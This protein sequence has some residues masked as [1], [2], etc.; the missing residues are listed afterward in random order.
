MASAARSTTILRFGPYELDPTSGQL[1]KSGTLLKLH[2]QP[3][4]VLLLLVSEPGKVVTREEIQHCLWNGNTLVDCDG[5]INFCVKQIRAALCDDVEEPIYIETLPRR[6]Y[7]F[8]APINQAHGADAVIP[9]PAVAGNNGHEQ[10]VGPAADEVSP[11]D[12]PERL[13]ATATPTG[14]GKRAFVFVALAA[15]SLGV[16]L[17]AGLAHLY[18]RTAKLSEK[19]T[20]VLADLTNNTGDSVFDGALKQALTTELAQSPFLNLL[21]ES[22]INGTLRMMARPA[23]E[24]VTG[25]TGREICMRTGSKALLTS[26]ISKLGN[27][28]LFGLN[29]VECAN[30]AILASAN[31]EASSKENVLKAVSK[32]STSLRA[33]LGESLPSVQKY[34]VPIQATTSSL[35]ALQS[36]SIAVRLTPTEGDAVTIPF[37]ER[38]LQFDPNFASAY[39]SLARRYTNLNQ[40]SLALENATKA[41]ELRDHVTELEKLQ[42][43]AAYFRATGDLVSLNK[44]LE[45]WMGDYPR[46]SGPHARMCT[47]D[48]F[49]G[50]Y[51]KALE[52]CREA[53]RLDPDNLGSY[54]DLAQIYLDL[55][56]YDEAQQTCDQALA[57]NLPC[58]ALY[59]LDFLRG[60]TKGMANEVA[61]SV[62]KFGEEDAFLSR[63]SNTK[64]YYGQLRQAREL[65]QR[66]TEA[67]VRSGL[68]EAA[69]LWRV[70]AALREAEFGEIAEARRGMREALRI[71]P[72]RNVKVM[73]AITLAGIGEIEQARELVGELEQSDPSNTLLK[74]YWFPVINAAIELR[75]GQSSNAVILLGAT[76]PYELGRP[77]PN[78]FGTLYPIYLRG[79]AYLAAR[80]GTKA[81]AEFQKIID[82][83]GVFVNYPTGSLARLGLA[84]AYAL[85][86]DSA[87]AKEA[88]GDFFTLWKEADPDVPILKQAKAEYAKLQ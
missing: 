52:E 43:S 86:G 81:A 23:N 13:G 28:Y 59:D 88:Y 54:D 44:I 30:G 80:D 11:P 69:A 60:D 29:A 27:H 70:N 62:G 22:K 15:V 64:A 72:S 36:F 21:P 68:R 38:A 16:L 82:H 6:G 85:E 83:P 56:R 8:I 3:F 39:A 77:S 19:D 1:R 20:I 17:I 46:A 5:G 18:P 7:R 63:D 25:D 53:L 57:R 61:T 40:P 84:R 74:I 76:A 9:F 35:E 42:I 66:S 37:V 78:D 71:S 34:D 51:E 26:S 32:A 87:K 49:L 65:S 33:K 47:N 75:Q 58:G 41:Y 4:R 10:R 12:H 50:Q 48:G 67:A 2:P 14:K 31:T 24:R 55:E 73:G 79:R 45:L